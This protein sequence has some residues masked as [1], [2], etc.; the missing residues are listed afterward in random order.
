MY[1]PPI[2]LALPLA[3]MQLCMFLSERWF[4]CNRFR[5]FNSV[6]L[7]FINP[8]R[9]INTVTV[10]GNTKAKMTEKEVS[11]LKFQLASFTTDPR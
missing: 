1:P 7:Y 9:D 3:D 4:T 8:Q 2:P 10:S 6:Q 5:H 11:L